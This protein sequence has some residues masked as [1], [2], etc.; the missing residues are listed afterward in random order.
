MSHGLARLSG[1]KGDIRTWEVGLESI[2]KL[3][4]GPVG[5]SRKSR[6]NHFHIGNFGNRSFGLH[7]NPKP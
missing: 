3:F 6:Q 1:P 2:G 5:L 7:P 4:K